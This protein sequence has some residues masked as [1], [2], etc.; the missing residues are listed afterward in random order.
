MKEKIYTIPVNEAFKEDCECPLCTLEK[1][2]ENEY[3]D[4]TL[5][6][7]LMESDSRLDT[8]E[9]G[10]CKRHFEL[11]YNSE[12]N[13][14]GL[15]LIINT[16]INH[17]Y[18]MLNRLFNKGVPTIEKDSQIPFLKN[19]FLKFKNNQTDGGKT[20]NEIIETLVSL[21]NKCAICS[22]LEYTMDRYIDVILYLWFK[23]DEFRTN[24]NNKKGFCLEH[25]RLLLERSRK[26][27]NP[28][29]TAI[30]ANNLIK[31][32]LENL[33]RI[34]DEVG[35]FTKKFDYRYK[36]APWGNSKDALPRSIQ[37]IAGYCNLK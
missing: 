9:K 26:Y 10:F 36:D 7:S 35:W 11:L 29:K 31:I 30:F 4:Y 23:E 13:K 32:Q 18:E 25:F 28:K 12:E 21:E 19:I 34:N 24:F 15:G 37:K 2:L 20:I 1:K 27:L 5:G 33:Q 3:V 22:K 8:N 6:P 17:Q 16:H 14:L